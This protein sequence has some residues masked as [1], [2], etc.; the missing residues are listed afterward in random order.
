MKARKKTTRKLSL[1]ERQARKERA[2]AKRDDY[3]ADFASRIISML[4]DGTAPWQRP[5]AGSP[6]AAQAMRPFNPT[7][8]TVYKGCNYLFLSM[9]GYADPR[10]MT[11]KQAAAN[12]Y[13]VK[14]G[15][16]GLPIIFWK[17][18][19]KEECETD[20][21]GVEKC[22]MKTRVMTR[23]YSVFN[24]AQIE[25]IEDWDVP[26]TDPTPKQLW[27]S[28][29]RGD[30]ILKESGA[31]I[32][33]INGNSAAYYPMTDHIM[34]P[35]RHQFPQA[36]GYYGTALH[37]L[38]HWTGHESRLNRNLFDR[39]TDSY[40]REELRAEIATWMLCSQLGLP[41]DPT[42]H[43]SYIDT[44]VK[45][46]EDDPFEIISAAQQSEKIKNYLLKFDTQVQATP[47]EVTA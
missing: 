10:Y 1:K 13:Q 47:K 35:K 29:E 6:D 3:Y 42:N 17:F 39:K 23:F 45:R 32:K 41:N 5:W 18:D 4:K 9:S 46:I 11:Y 15:A 16:T 31:D 25:G 22:E 34:L 38:A 7:T 30:T 37:E 33:H 40:A 43:A 28:C 21:A 8:G 2:L 12:G 14:R 36:E 27:E 44:W 20:E 19:E 26:S 24:A